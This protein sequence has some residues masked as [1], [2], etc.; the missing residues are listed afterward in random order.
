MRQ[1]WNVAILVYLLVWLLTCMPTLASNE[2]IYRHEIRTLI[3]QP[4]LKAIYDKQ[5]E[6][7]GMRKLPAHEV[8]TL[9]EMINPGMTEKNIDALMSTIV[10]ASNKE[11]R[12]HLYRI[13]LQ[14]CLEGGGVQ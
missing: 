2:D 11:E 13:S 4:C 6:Q 12:M 7:S 9:H 14:S 1:Q 10:Y 8:M 3:I 5:A